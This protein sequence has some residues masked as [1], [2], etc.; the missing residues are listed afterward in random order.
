MLSSCWWEHEKICQLSIIFIIYNIWIDYIRYKHWY[1]ILFEAWLEVF[2]WF[3]DFIFKMFL[4]SLAEISDPPEKSFIPGRKYFD[5][6]HN[7]KTQVDEHN[8]LLKISLLLVTSEQHR[9]VNVNISYFQAA[10]HLRC[11]HSLIKFQNF[12]KTPIDFKAA[13]KHHCLWTLKNW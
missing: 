7:L 3:R 9:S 1:N 10:N 2:C 13:A 8:L 12:S 6:P 11:L 5:I 4:K